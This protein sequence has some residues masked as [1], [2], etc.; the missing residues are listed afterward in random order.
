[1]LLEKETWQQSEYKSSDL[2]PASP[3]LSPVSPTLSPASPESPTY[4]A[5]EPSGIKL[6][7]APPKLALDYGFIVSKAVE[8]VATESDLTASFII[9][10]PG[11]RPLAYL[12]YLGTSSS[13]FG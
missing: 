4:T 3:T 2:S 6:E 11:F 5:S 7:A 9:N 8:S 1:M 13:G 10:P 12:P